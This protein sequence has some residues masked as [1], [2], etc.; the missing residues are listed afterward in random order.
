MFHEGQVGTILSAQSDNVG[1]MFQNTDLTNPVTAYGQTVASFESPTE[2]NWIQNTGTARP[3]YGRMPS[4]GV[5]NLLAAID[6]PSEDFSSDRWLKSGVSV[7]NN[8]DFIAGFPAQRVV[9][10]SGSGPKVLRANPVAA[11]GTVG[12]LVGFLVDVTNVSN[13]SVAIGINDYRNVKFTWSSPS[14]ISVTFSPAAVPAVTTG[15]TVVG[16]YA[17]LIWMRNSEGLPTTGR[18]LVLYVGHFGSYSGEGDYALVAYC[19]PEISESPTPYQR[20]NAVWDVTQQGIP[21]S[22]ILYYDLGDDAMNTTLAAGD[23]SIGLAGEKGIFFDRVT[24]SGGT[25]TI[26]PTTY[27]GGPIG[28]ITQLIGNRIFEVVIRAEEFT[29]TEKQQL[30]HRWMILG[31]P[32]VWEAGA[33]AVPN[34]DFTG[35]KTFVSDAVYVPTGRALYVPENVS[36]M[37]VVDGNLL[38]TGIATMAGLNGYTSV[39]GITT[40][41][42][43]IY[44]IRARRISGSGSAELQLYVRTEAAQWIVV[45]PSGA[46]ESEWREIEFVGRVTG[47]SAAIISQFN[48]ATA[49]WEVDY[50]SA[51]ELT[52][53]PNP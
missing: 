32:H 29:E 25:F 2:T 46:T 19:Q 28:A 33:E 3:T 40:G 5:R 4:V 36:Y 8:G 16:D 9:V 26:G 38:F 7:T 27:T 35:G 41:D 23:Y 34:W 12:L 24:H 51:K 13:K 45:V 20:V 37:D 39:S 22:A 48:D 53:N 44:R 15:Y 50:S 47:T 42:V 30:I 11:S 43:V 10:G 52:P 18:H 6:T 1:E 21:D 49:T 17:A 31:A 14:D